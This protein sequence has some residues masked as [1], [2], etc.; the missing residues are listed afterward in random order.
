ME[1]DIGGQAKMKPGNS[2]SLEKAKELKVSLVVSRAL[3]GV[4]VRLQCNGSSGAISRNEYGVENSGLVKILME[5]FLQ[6]TNVNC[7]VLANYD[8]CSESMA[9]VRKSRIKSMANIA[10][11][12]LEMF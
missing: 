2:N 9:R 7:E 1:A 12:N 6:D 10:S 3:A 8:G 11:Q 5:G 4:E